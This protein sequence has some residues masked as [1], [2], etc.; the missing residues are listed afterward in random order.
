MNELPVTAKDMS[1]WISYCE[2]NYNG[3]FWVFMPRNIC[4]EVSVIPEP[5]LTK[6]DRMNTQLQL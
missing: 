1:V 2:Y 4:I 3:W 5:S 6:S